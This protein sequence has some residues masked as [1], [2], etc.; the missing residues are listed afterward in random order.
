[1]LLQACS[2]IVAVNQAKVVALRAD[3]PGSQVGACTTVQ[4]EHQNVT[5]F[6]YICTFPD[7][8]N[9]IF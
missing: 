6:C 5:A 4:T 3:N 7:I 1:M 2:W 8:C 9:T